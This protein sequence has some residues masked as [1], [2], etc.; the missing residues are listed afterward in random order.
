MVI[1]GK[2]NSDLCRKLVRLCRYMRMIEKSLSSPK[3]IGL[4][5]FY[6]GPVTVLLTKLVGRSVEIEYDYIVDYRVAA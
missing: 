3:D 4:S 5:T 6:S 2:A 1:E